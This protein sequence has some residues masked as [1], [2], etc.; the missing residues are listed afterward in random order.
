MCLCTDDGDQLIMMM[1][2]AKT[3]QFKFGMDFQTKIREVIADIIRGNYSSISY[4][5]FLLLCC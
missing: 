1:N 3:V 4:S 2:S 5:N